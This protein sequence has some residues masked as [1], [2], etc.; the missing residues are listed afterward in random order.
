MATYTPEAPEMDVDEY[1]DQRQRPMRLPLILSALAALLSAVAVIAA[2]VL[3]NDNN[4]TSSSSPSVTQ[5]IRQPAEPKF[6]SNAAAAGALV[7]HLKG[8]NASCVKGEF[9]E[10]DCEYTGPTPGNKK[11]YLSIRVGDKNVVIIQHHQ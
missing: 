1:I 11:Q 6:A 9:N 3:L 2:V 4:S 10:Y 5:V 8:G 7:D